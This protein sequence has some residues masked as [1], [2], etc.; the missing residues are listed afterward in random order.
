MTCPAAPGV[1]LIPKPKVA[2][3]RPELAAAGIVEAHVVNDLTNA[4][5]GEPKRRSFSDSLSLFRP[6]VP[7]PGGPLPPLPPWV[8]GLVVLGVY[9]ALYGAAT[10]ALGAG[11]ARRLGGKV[12]R[13]GAKVWR[14]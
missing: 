6:I 8:A 9:A 1:L 3:A 2:N 5:E 12:A 14:R 7:L 11:E 13:V 10:Y 4:G